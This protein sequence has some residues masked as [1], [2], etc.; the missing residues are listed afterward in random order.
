MINSFSE[1]LEIFSNKLKE[2]ISHSKRVILFQHKNPDLDSLGSNI[3]FLNYIFNFNPE[4]EVFILSTDEPS[5]NMF[6]RVKK[7]IPEHFLI[8]DP[9]KFDFKHDDLLVFIDFA[10]ISRATKF[11]EFVIPTSS[12]VFVVDH[13]LVTPKYENAYVEPANQSASSIVYEL[14]ALESIKIEKINYEFIIMGI[15]GDSG[16]LRYRDNKFTQTL[17]IINRFITEYGTGSYY[18]IIESLEQNRALEE[19]NLQKVYLNN[20]VYNQNFAY[21]SITNQQRAEAGVSHSF[22]ETTNGAVLIRNIENTKFVFAVTQDLTFEDRYNLSFRTCSG[23]EFIVR[24]L[25]EKLGGGGH[26]FAAGAQVKA[27]DM[28]SAIKLVLSAI[29]EFTGF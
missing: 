25:A 16:F 14:L 15:L 8:I 1:K 5:R 9:S 7:I 27:S 26:A 3:G 17:G 28:D 6:E 23:S 2:K 21:T 13:H 24:D 18:E 22:S 11:P 19:Y 4:A 20:M 10:E 29:N 12:N